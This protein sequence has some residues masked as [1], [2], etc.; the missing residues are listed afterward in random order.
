MRLIRAFAGLL[1]LAACQPLPHPF[2]GDV[3]K[4]GS[5]L[6]SLPD[7][8][9]VAI[10]PIEGHPRA[11]A[12]R[13]APALAKALQKRNVAASAD[14]TSVTSRELEGMVHEMRSA[15]GRATLLALW[16]VRD[17]RGR[18]V[19]SRVVRIGGTAKDW[20]AADKRAVARIAA[21]NAEALATLLHGT[22]PSQAAGAP[23]VRGRAAAQ[24]GPRL[25]IGA[26]SGAPG[27]G[28]AA[29]ARAIALTL[30]EQH[31]AIVTDP[32]AKADLVLDATVAIG[33]P[34]AG[35]QHVKIVWRLR[36]PKGGQI[37]T[38]GQQNDVP[39][40]SLDGKW[41]NVAYAVA[42]AAQGGIRRLAAGAASARSA[43][44][45]AGGRG[46]RGKS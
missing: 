20:R 7:S 26:I 12:E 3:P 37:G 30:A 22:T 4:R 31:I 15:D 2:A 27:D 42:T 45:A 23:A 39:A 6:L 44:N 32:K 16:R 35:M 11:L 18:L 1:L 14:T 38:V 24:A 13:L 19:G 17:P 25:R 34:K 8:T 43:P 10:A 28:D 41:G 36:R 46:G 9:S 5:P 29:L 40:G 33:K 21:V